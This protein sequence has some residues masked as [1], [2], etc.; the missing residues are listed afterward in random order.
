MRYYVIAGEASGDLHASNLMKEIRK[1]DGNASFRCWGGDRMKEQGGELV[2]HYRKTAY[3]GFTDVFLHLRRIWNFINLCKRD[4]LSYG[5][6]ALILVDYPGFNLRM[7]E[8]AHKKGFR[9]VYYI[10]P[11]LWAWKSSRVRKIKSF[12]DR[13]YVILPF[14]KDFYSRYG[15]PVEYVGHPLLDAL[16]EPRNDEKDSFRSLHSPG[17]R[18]VIAL[19]PGSR[20]QEVKRIL[21][22]M[23]SVIPHFPEYQFVIGGLSSLTAGFYH[24]IIQ[25][26]RVN[27]VFGQSDTL[28][29]NAVAA[30]VTSG[31]A[32]L[33][34]ALH[35][36]P[37]IICYR[38]EN[39]SYLI[40]RRLIKVPHIGL[41]NLI[42]ERGTVK[43][44][45]QCELNTVNL[46]SELR[47]ILPG[48]HKRE[49]MLRAYELLKLKLGGSGAS[50]RTAGLI[51]R[52]LNEVSVS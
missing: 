23:L 46:A 21:P 8:F 7:A 6:D 22:A 29:N 44:L 16:G 34:T 27:V 3:M 43:E 51:W 36:V 31:T 42:M 9:V 1:L 48:G 45:I 2:E 18:P 17:N 40:A 10:S 25:S 47:Q 28:L 15:Y 37:Q 26:A 24:R 41:V 5:P 20:K 12:V 52:Y 50:A 32:T 30:L 38:G 13:M 4:I 14:E 49:Q 19:L 33:E 35:G 11:Q 39:L